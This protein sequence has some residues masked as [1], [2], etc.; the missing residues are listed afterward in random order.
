MEKLNFNNQPRVEKLAENQED[1]ELLFSE[2]KE[3]TTREKIT[4]GIDGQTIEAEKYYFEYP[5]HIQEETGILGYERVKIPLDANFSEKNQKKILK[6]LSRGE[7]PYCTLNH[8]LSAYVRQEESK[9]QYSDFIKDRF[10]IQKVF[11]M[12]LIERKRF[13]DKIDDRAIFNH[14][15]DGPTTNMRNSFSLIE[16]GTYNFS[17]EEYVGKLPDEKELDKN[18]KLFGVTMKDR[19]GLDVYGGTFFERRDGIYKNEVAFGFPLYGEDP[20]FDEYLYKTLSEYMKIIDVKEVSFNLES[21]RAFASAFAIYITREC[22][23]KFGLNFDD[24]Q[25][26]KLPNNL[27]EKTKEISY[28]LFKENNIEVSED[29]AFRLGGNALANILYYNWR[30]TQ[31]ELQLPIFINND[32]IPQLSWGHAKYAHYFNDKGF[33]FFK[34]KHTEK[35]PVKKNDANNLNS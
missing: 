16:K 32:K 5:K 11:D 24:E 18:G 25:P 1:K 8:V 30:Y 13:R 28:F 3:S 23:K 19:S 15:P 9:K 34:F 22:N 20:F 10:F 7:Y 33:N 21:N 35:L 4:L 27:L 12:S 6:E 29:F 26:Y 17:R 2:Q 31:S 14:G